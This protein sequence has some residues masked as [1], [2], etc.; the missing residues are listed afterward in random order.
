MDPR[1][2][3][4]FFCGACFGLAVGGAAGHLLVWN[5][6]Q[7]ERTA[8]FDRTVPMNTS[9]A[10]IGGTD[11]LASL[12]IPEVTDIASTPAPLGGVVLNDP[13]HGD[14]PVHAEALIEAPNAVEASALSPTAVPTTAVPT[15]LTP[16][17]NLSIEQAK[18]IAE[19]TTESPITSV[20]D[21][22]PAVE[23]EP[24]PTKAVPSSETLKLDP[25]VVEM[26]KDELE[27]VSEQQREVWADAL[28]GMS[29]ADAAGIIVMWK[30]FGQKGEGP[31]HLSAPPPLFR[32]SH[33]ETAPTPL[34]PNASMLSLLQ[35]APPKPSNPQET[36]AARIA[37]HNANNAQTCGYLTLVPMFTELSFDG[38][39][40]ADDSQ[41][42]GYRLRLDGNRSVKTFNPSH[43]SLQHGHFFRVKLPSGEEFFTRVGRLAKDAENRLCIDLGDRDL[44]VSPEVKLPEGTSRPVV[45]EG[46]L[47]VI[48]TGQA[49]P[50]PVGPLQV[51]VFFDPTR[52]QPQ[53]RCLYSATPASGQPTLVPAELTQETLEYPAP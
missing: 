10:G 35:S 3:L 36:L 50:V 38:A 42:V 6:V 51:A 25:E 11:L 22:A 5:R 2:R 40:A 23:K 26:L 20:A 27:G 19:T 15:A 24:S 21:S 53:G 34:P 12:S 39:S 29:P 9:S 41:I 4:S 44:P 31:G 28:Q 1:W 16:P 18:P 47:K 30:K 7:P 49:E 46:Q 37:E 17:G 33:P 45:Q 48:V 13:D 43:T 8:Y 14:Q 32:S 52:L